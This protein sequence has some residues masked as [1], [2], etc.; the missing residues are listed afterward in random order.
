MSLDCSGLPYR[1][2]AL[3]HFMINRARVAM[4]AGYEFGPR[5]DCFLRMNVACPR[6]MLEEGLRR[7]CQALDRV[8]PGDVLDDFTYTTPWES[9]RLSDGQSQYT[10]LLANRADAP[11]DTVVTIAGK[12]CESG[13]LIQEN[14]SLPKAEKGDILAVMTTG[15]YNYSMASHYNRI[16]N[17]PVVMLKGGES[18]VAVKRETYADLMKNDL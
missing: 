14:V 10:F 11:A 9:R 5:G 18:Y 16:P 6:S 13:D 15:A 4:S 1:G 7:M 17:P 2:M 8:F 3:E 12:C